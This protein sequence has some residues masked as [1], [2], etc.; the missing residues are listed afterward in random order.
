MSSDD[1]SINKSN[2]QK[3]RFI[4]KPLY[5]KKHDYNDHLNENEN[6]KQNYNQENKNTSIYREFAKNYRKGNYSYKSNIRSNDNINIMKMSDDGTYYK[7]NR[8]NIRSNH[9]NN[10][11][12]DVYEEEILKLQL[13]DYDVELRE[14]QY[15]IDN[16]IKNNSELKNSNKSK[17][18][19]IVNLT[20]HLKMLED[21]LQKNVIYE[22]QLND[23]ELELDNYTNEIMNLKNMIKQ[24]ESLTNEFDLIAEESLKKFEHYESVN[25]S[26]LN[27]NIKLKR[28][29]IFFSEKIQEMYSQEDLFLTNIENLTKLESFNKDKEETNIIRKKLKALSGKMMNSEMNDKDIVDKFNITTPDIELDVFLLKQFIE[30]ILAREKESQSNL[31]TENEKKIKNVYENEL[32]QKSKELTKINDDMNMLMKELAVFKSKLNEYETL[33]EKNKNEYNDEIEYKEKELEEA[34]NSLKLLNK[35]FKE[36]ELEYKQKLLD[37]SSKIKNL[38]ELN[39]KLNNE[40][41]VKNESSLKLNIN[42]EKEKDHNREIQQE[43]II[44]KSAHESLENQIN[45]LKSNLQQFQKEI[46]VKNEN[47]IKSENEHKKEV[48]LLLKNIEDFKELNLNLQKENTMLKEELIKINEKSKYLETTMENKKLLEDEVNGLKSSNDE[49]ISIINELQSKLK[50]NE[51]KSNLKSSKLKKE[52]SLLENVIANIKEEKEK[53][54]QKVRL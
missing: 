32:L 21:K 7:L 9:Y 14:K 44:K 3:D 34:N 52:V 12:V 23:A 13:E 29:L 33:I 43:L 30:K 48:L 38:D 27:D 10:S 41:E 11:D 39:T 20:E 50:L 8:N 6:I 15:Y 37:L 31:F 5:E 24:K 1:K 36:V 46:E 40:L 51:D 19:K 26:L 25:K 22:Q 2:F 53:N 45:N 54:D 47:F 42:L 18:D 4:E 49:L 16:L 28:D 17:E 35:N